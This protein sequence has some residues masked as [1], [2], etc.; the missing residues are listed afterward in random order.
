MPQGLKFGSGEHLQQN[1]KT[2]QLMFNVLY[3]KIDETF[4]VETDK[5][6]NLASHK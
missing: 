3:I 1:V 2:A 6:E 5:S 4:W